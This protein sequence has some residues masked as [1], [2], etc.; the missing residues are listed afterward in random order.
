MS[1]LADRSI[2]AVTHLEDAHGGKGI[3][4]NRCSAN[5]HRQCLVHVGEV[6]ADTACAARANGTRM[7]SSKVGFAIIG[8]AHGQ[9]ALEGLGVGVVVGAV[10]RHG[11]GAVQVG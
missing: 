4:T 9:G 1:V 3:R 10:S 6:G 5:G 11:C 8:I 7:S 2:T